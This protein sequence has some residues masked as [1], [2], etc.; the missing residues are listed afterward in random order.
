MFIGSGDV[1]LN[2]IA[3]FT[4]VF[5]SFTAIIADMGK[6]YIPRNLHSSSTRFKV[7]LIPISYTLVCRGGNVIFPLLIQLLQR[8]KYRITNEAVIGALFIPLGLGNIRRGSA[9]AILYC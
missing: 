9:Y 4:Q 5:T 3:S 8:E 2:L 7:L 1:L 6:L